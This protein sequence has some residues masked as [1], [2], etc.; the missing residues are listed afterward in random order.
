MKIIYAFAAVALAVLPAVAR[1]DCR[2]FGAA[3][4]AVS[5]IGRTS[6]R[7]DGSVSFDWTGTYLRT[8][9]TGGK[10]AASLS[11]RG[12]TYF[13]VFVD[14]KLHRVVNISDNDTVV[15]FVGGI[16][17][18]PHEVMIQKRTEGE[19][20][21]PTFRK[22]ILPPKGALEGVKNV[23]ARHIEFIGNS[24]T[25]GYGVEGKSPYEAF[26]IDTENCNDSYAAMI[27]RYFDAD[28]T[29]IAHSGQGI[30]RNYGDSVR[31]SAIS[32]KDR[33]TRTF[34]TDTVG[35]D[36]TTGYRPDIV[37]INLGSN[38]FSTEPNPYRN[39]FIGAYER[40]IRTL[41]DSYGDV[42]VLCVYSTTIMRSVYGYFEELALRLNDP[43]VH[44]FQMHPGILV[45]PEDYGAVFHPNRMGQTKL[46][47]ELIPA[48][49]AITK[50]PVIPA[51][52]I[53]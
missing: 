51:K 40:M 47:M 43:N 36:F 38:D 49:S 6:V 52:A 26:R 24:L 37:V 17:R 33:I 35:W 16:D 22:F 5:Y 13:N 53:E 20:G 29:M 10:L 11:N 2:E 21:R 45:N 31:V 19:Y 25:C 12:E 41:R 27:A 46:A 3:D 44:I 39:E 4:S 48:V 34:D 9:L 32:M 18:R 28:Y 7:D 14:G 42:P 30:V 15:E 23:P 1:N 8:T 50:W